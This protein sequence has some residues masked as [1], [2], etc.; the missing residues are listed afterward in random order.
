M[1][2]IQLT[3]ELLGSAILYFQISLQVHIRFMLKML[4]IVQ[5]T[6]QLLYMIQMKLLLILQL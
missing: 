6:L 3:E 5:K 4:M 2:N 1:L